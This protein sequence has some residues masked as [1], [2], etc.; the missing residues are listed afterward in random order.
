MIITDPAVPISAPISANAPD[1]QR[2]SLSLICAF[3]E[4]R[5]KRM[6]TALLL[7][8]LPALGIAMTADDEIQADAMAWLSLVDQQKYDASWDAASSLFRS[9]INE[10][11][12][13]KAASAG[14]QPLGPL[15]F[16]TLQ[17]MARATSLPGAPEGAYAILQFQDRFQ[18]K[19]S[20]I[21]TLTLMHEGDA[22]KTAG[23]FI[24]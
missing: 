22:W 12:W 20:A 18:N 16:R 19:A 1:S 17:Q 5:M 6:L 4:I 14:R 13:T 15:V 8:L 24:K 7:V 23:Y 11:D 9:Q 2:R 3:R 10:S 21:E